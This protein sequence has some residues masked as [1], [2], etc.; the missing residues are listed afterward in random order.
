MVRF[1]LFLSFSK[2]LAKDL[3]NKILDFEECVF[4]QRR[5]QSLGAWNTKHSQHV[6]RLSTATAADCVLEHNALP[7]KEFQKGIQSIWGVQLEG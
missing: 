1:P 7:V 5:L 2:K 4:R 6:A 3:N